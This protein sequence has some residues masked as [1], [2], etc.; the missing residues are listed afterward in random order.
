M[1]ERLIRAGHL[2]RYVRETVRR[3]KA[4]PT[5]ERIAASAELLLEPQPTINYI[6]GGPTD[7]QYQSKCQKKIVIACSH[8]PSP[9]KHH[10]RPGQHQSS[11]AN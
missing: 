2:R 10:P 4:T 7:D 5:V 1:V 3:A 6:L 8:S 11:L 9:G